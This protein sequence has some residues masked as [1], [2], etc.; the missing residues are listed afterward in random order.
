VFK[1][2]GGRAAV[3]DAQ[4][5]AAPAVLRPKRYDSRASS[6]QV[7]SRLNSNRPRHR[8]LTHDDI[9]AWSRSSSRCQAARNA[10]DLGDE[11]KASRRAISMPR[12]PIQD[13]LDE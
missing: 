3:L 9:I 1:K 4:G 10:E 7:N 13:H 6:L 11:I 2:Q 5:A 12:E 8:T